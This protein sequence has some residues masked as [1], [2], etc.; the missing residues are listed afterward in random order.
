MFPQVYHNTFINDTSTYI[1]DGVQITGLW[2][3]PRIEMDACFIYPQHISFRKYQSS[4]TC[5]IYASANWINICSSNGLSTVRRQVIIWTNVELLSTGPI[6]LNSSEI[7]I[8]MHNLSYMKL[9]LKMPSAKWWPFG[10]GWRELNVTLCLIGIWQPIV[11]KRHWR[12][13]EWQSC[14]VGI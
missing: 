11:S 14:L 3:E 10:P 1:K 6:G 13:N 4:P 5:C 12:F 2:D 7:G 9:D 8:K